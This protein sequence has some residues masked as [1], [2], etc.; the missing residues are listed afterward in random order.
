MFECDWLNAPIRLFRSYR[1]KCY[2]IEYLVRAVAG[3]TA[4]LGGRGEGALGVA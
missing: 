4:R 2:A 1:I 3:E